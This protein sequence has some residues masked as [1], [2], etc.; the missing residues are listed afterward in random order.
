MSTFASLGLPKWLVEN[1]EAMRITT[2]TNIQAGCIPEI[3]KGRDCI[4]GAKTGSGKTIAFGAPMLAN[5]SKD[6]SGIYGV[7]LTPTRELA[8]QIADQFAA[9][10]ATVNLKVRLVIGGQSMTDQV[11]VIKE[12]PHFLIATP[13]RLA[14]IIMENPDETRGLKRVKYL[15]LDEADRLLTDSFTD[16]L[17]TC[18]EALPDSSKRQTLLFTATVTDSVRSLKDKPVAK[19]KQP[20]FLHELDQVDAVKIPSTLR[21]L[22]CLAPVV[23]K[24]SMLHNILTSDEYKESTAIV[25]ANR[26]ET[27]EI[28][29]RTLRHLEVT[30]TSLHSEMPQSERT[31][32]LHR[33][34]AGAARVL[35]ATDLASRGLDIPSVELVI[36]FDIPRDPD[37]Y[38]H[39]VGRTARAGRKGDAI[40][41]VTPNDLSRVLAI[42]ERVGLKMEELAISDNKVIS[43]SLKAVSK[44]KI[45]ARMEMEKD[46][47]GER[48]RRRKERDNARKRYKD[49]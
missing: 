35:I 46:G 31:N 7:V 9:L 44:A 8:M 14:H 37:D 10:G 17:Q 48:K 18:F 40:S 22:Y 26:S 11:A 6:P 21:L 19:G 43:Q 32:S 49:I 20:V 23:V 2:P 39:R 36:N 15:V 28:L 27:A 41:M 30:T 33:F 1:L 24:E 25:F 13:G 45:E 38:V 3:L 29:R 42:E 12:N 34:R 5:W 4:G 47:F 16:H